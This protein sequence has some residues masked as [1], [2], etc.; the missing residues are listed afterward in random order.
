MRDMAQAALWPPSSPRAGRRLVRRRTVAL[1]GVTFALCACALGAAASS[2]LASGSGYFVTFVARSC[3]AYTDIYANRAR[4]DILESLQ[5][6]GPDTQYGNSG[7]LVN[8]VDESR[9]PQD[10]C[11]P[12]PGWQFTMGTGYRSRA[13]TGPWG[14]LSI[15]TN[16][17]GGTPIVTQ[18]STPLLDQDGVKVGHERIAGA[19]T[20]ELTAAE[21]NQAGSPSAL[22]AQGGTQTD[23]V[24]VSRFPGPQYGFGALRC[25]TDNLNGDNVE[26]VYFPAGVE[27]VFCY[28]LYVNSSPAAGLITIEKRVTGNS[29]ADKPSFPFSGN[30]SYNP[31]G[32]QL[33]NGQSKD[34]HR[35]GGVTWNVTE[36]PTA[37][38]TLTS[39]ACHATAA[40]GAPGTSTAAV[41]GTT[42]S[43]HLV[44]GDH[45]TCVYSN[46]YV[47]PTGGLTIRKL[48][49]GGVGQ[50]HY[51][52]TPVSGA[53]DARDVEATT[54]EPNVPVDA[55]P[56]LLTLAPGSYRISERP[57]LSPDG[58]WQ[59]VDV[60]C[61]GAHESTTR[62]VTVEIHRGAATTCSF[63][64]AFTPRGSISIAKITTGATG[65]SGFLV[66]SRSGVPAQYRSRATTIHSGVAAS[67]TPD[68]AADS[69]D[70]L[71]LGSYAIV[72]ELPASLPANG[73][74][75]TS[76][77][78]NGTLV[79]FDQGSVQIS[80]TPRQPHVHCV[81]RDAFTTQPPPPDPSP[82]VPPAPIN[83]DQPSYELSDLNITKH[84]SPTVVTEGHV[85]TYRITV[86]N[87]GP[88]PAERVVLNDQPLGRVA[89]VGVHSPAGRCQTGVPIVCQLGTIKP[90]A[91]VTVTVRLVPT[92]GSLRLINR[93]I[94]GSA[95]HERNLANN[96]A[97]ATIRVLPRPPQPPAPPGRG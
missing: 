5:N 76:V 38:Y 10:L 78:C 88:D 19:T 34:F 28:A 15:V 33:A 96:V 93:A 86:R 60:S 74:E 46:R 62:P 22:W 25:A 59:L 17:F 12:I 4:N 95:T 30:I 14:S 53:G 68:T 21:R 49:T 56:S 87:L 55:E 31:K 41:S 29:P 61:T 45:V 52:V 48:T 18:A 90:S 82:P 27:H 47:P 70:H 73:W 69:T 24:L 84:A 13:V 36:G 1:L 7:R 23:P 77:D 80:L 64:N 16:A 75:L 91:A 32:F 42:A 6:L 44:A 67:A 94:V 35:A 39:V 81:Y 85:V 50:F 54:T 97:H 20:I 37:N 26:F 57:A 65:T 83:P 66:S 3:P 92:N 43:I 8:P 58:R 40:T 2:A 11:T 63:T 72:E 71:A 79:P 89:V 9:A 51:V